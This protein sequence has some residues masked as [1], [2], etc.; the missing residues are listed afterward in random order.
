MTCR[1][2]SPKPARHRAVALSV[3]DG[4]ARVG[5]LLD[6]GG[7]RVESFDANGKLIGVFPNRIE[8]MRSISP[9]GSRR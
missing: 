2:R 3:Y 8:A 9:A 6:H 1:R 4:G 7:D 5:E